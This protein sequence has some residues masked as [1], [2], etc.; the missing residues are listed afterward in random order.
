MTSDAELNRKILEWLGFR[1]L[2]G[3]IKVQNMDRHG[4]RLV[5]NDDGY[6]YD[7]FGWTFWAQP[8][9]E[10]VGKP[11][12]FTDPILGIAYLFKW[13][14]PKLTKSH[15][16][17]FRRLPTKTE[18]GCHIYVGEERISSGWRETPALALARAIEKLIDGEV[19]DD[20]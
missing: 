6:E 9:K 2:T 1:P 13:A 11:P 14:V 3:I 15:L 17:E 16:I 18:W 5:L 12:D 20:R 10:V 19:K 7:L 4:Q 8:D